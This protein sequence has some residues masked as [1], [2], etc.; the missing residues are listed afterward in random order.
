MVPPADEF[1][2][3]KRP[4]SSHSA[5][6]LALPVRDITAL[7][8]GYR[9]S[10]WEVGDGLSLA[11]PVHRRWL[12]DGPGRAMAGG[13]CGFAAVSLDANLA[14]ADPPLSGKAKISV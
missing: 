7:R 2:A 10:D 6:S 14:G 1:G 9:E 5:R 8:N 11:R 12:A 3:C 4:I 13:W